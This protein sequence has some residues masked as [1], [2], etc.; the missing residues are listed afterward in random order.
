ML[1][2]LEALVEPTARGDPMSALWWTLESTRELAAALTRQGHRIGR[3]KV[4]DLLHELDYSLQG[5]RKTREGS[6]HPDRNAQFAHITENWRGKPLIRHEVVVNLIGHTKTR[7]GLRV[8]AALDERQYPTGKKVDD[9]ELEAV[10]IRRADFHG[11]WN[12]T[13]TPAK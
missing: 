8:R 10:N 1:P 4:D 6:S 13:I 11:D 5:N 9:Q 7:K 2:D 12:D 3:Q